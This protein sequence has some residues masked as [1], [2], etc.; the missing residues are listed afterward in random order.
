MADGIEQCSGAIRDFS[1]PRHS[2]D[3]ATPL[4][5]LRYEAADQQSGTKNKR[6]GEFGNDEQPT[7][8]VA[9]Q[10]ETAIGLSVAAAGLEGVWI[11]PP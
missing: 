2:G 11:E 5:G 7:Q 1:T 3:S 9:F 6:N 10:I 4:G 8:T